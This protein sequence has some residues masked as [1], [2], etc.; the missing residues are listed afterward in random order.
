MSD[1]NAAVEKITKNPIFTFSKLSLD[2]F[3]KKKLF[4]LI[5]TFVCVVMAV[6]TL[7]YPFIILGRTI[8]SGYFNFGIQYAI[9]FIFAWLAV[10]AACWLGFYLWWNRRKKAAEIGS[11]EFIML[12]F[13]SEILITFGEWLGILFGVIGAVGGLFALIFLGRYSTGMLLAILFS[14]DGGGL[15]AGLPIVGGLLKYPV[16]FGPV[17][18][19]LI[20]LIS[21]FFAEMLWVLA[22]IANNTKETS[23]ELKKKNG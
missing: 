6:I 8:N 14:G 3:E 16:I 13:F 4:K 15:L 21:R 17:V 10:V 7:V 20:I 1:F 11:S 12:P 9:A 22:A 18:G 2:F 23:R 5:F 19:V